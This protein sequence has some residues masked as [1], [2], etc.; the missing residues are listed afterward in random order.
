MHR[1]L[2]RSPAPACAMCGLPCPHCSDPAR[3]PEGH[4]TT[5]AA[6]D[7]CEAGDANCARQEPGFLVNELIDGIEEDDWS[8]YR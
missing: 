2:G 8:G 3:A 7:P 6:E 1:N 4:R 5:L